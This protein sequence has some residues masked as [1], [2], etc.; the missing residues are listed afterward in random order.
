MD[1]NYVRD[2]VNEDI[3]M[4]EIYEHRDREAAGGEYAGGKAAGGTNASGEDAAGEDDEDFASQF[5]MDSGEGLDE[6]EEIRAAGVY[7]YI[8]SIFC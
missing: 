8:K 4:Q 3:V 1:L 7:I 6:S 5:L 2:E